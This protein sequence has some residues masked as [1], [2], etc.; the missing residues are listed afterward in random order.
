MAT[1]TECVRQ[2]EESLADEQLT[3]IRSMSL[4]RFRTS[5][6]LD[7][8]VFVR[9]QFKLWK[10]SALTKHFKAHGI[11]E[12]DDMSSAI[13]TALHGQ[14]RH[15]GFDEGELLGMYV[16]HSPSDNTTAD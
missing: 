6:H 2:L 10:D 11:F 4:D 3:E 9:N 7:L 5:A 8:G 15:G 13:L 16:G 1:L 12:P 14:L